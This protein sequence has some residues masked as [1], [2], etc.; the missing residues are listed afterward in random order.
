M[1]Y[2]RR[3]EDKKETNKNAKYESFEVI[4]LRFFF[5]SFYSQLFPECSI[6]NRYYFYRESNKNVIL[7]GV[8]VFLSAFG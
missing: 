3:G 8:N 6:I 4:G 5:A 1:N 2:Q 7:K